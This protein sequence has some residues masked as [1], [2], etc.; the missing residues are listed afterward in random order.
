ML[1]YEGGSIKIWPMLSMKHLTAPLGPLPGAP[2]WP[3]MVHSPPCGPVG[4]SCEAPS[5]GHLKTKHL[6]PWAALANT[7]ISGRQKQGGFASCF[8]FLTTSQDLAPGSSPRGTRRAIN[9]PVSQAADCFLQEPA[10]GSSPHSSLQC[11]SFLLSSEREERLKIVPPKDSCQ[12][13]GPL[14][15]SRPSCLHRSWVWG[16]QSAAI[17]PESPPWDSHG[18]SFRCTIWNFIFW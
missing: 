13:Q 3:E 9:L 14:T 11:P 18:H 17:F 16:G 15:V 1:S 4:P 8:G 10:H 6:G 7:S 5:P 12:A 2:K